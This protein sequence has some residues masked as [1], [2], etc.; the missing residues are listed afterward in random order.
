MRGLPLTPVDGFVLSRVDGKLTT[1]DLAA[2]TGLSEDQVSTS[3]DKLAELK[4]VA[5][6]PPDANP[7]PPVTP[8]PA[9]PAE[10]AP[11]P[12]PPLPP[13]APGPAAQFAVPED[14]PELQEVTD[15]ELDVRRRILG[16][17]SKLAELDHYELFNLERACD[18]KAVKRS[19]F[20][21]A[22]VFHPD[23]YFRKEIGSFKGMMEAIFGRATQAYEV[24]SDKT[25]RADYDAYLA[26]LDRTRGL[27]D[28][29]R[30]ALDDM[31]SAEAA[32]DSGRNS[33]PPVSS[34][35]H[36][37]VPTP[38]FGLTDTLRAAG[39]PSPA[40]IAAAQRALAARLMGGRAPR[41]PS[42]SQPPPVNQPKHDPG[43][44]LKRLHE[45]RVG[46][47][48]RAQLNKYLAMATEA[49]R[50]QDVIA[51]A[52]AYKVVLTV[53]GDDQ[54]IRAKAEK[55]IHEADIALADTYLR[56][57]QYEERSQSW[58]EAARSWGR[59]ASARPSDARAHDR[60]ANA[61]TRAEGDLHQAAEFAKKAI[62]M[63]GANAAFRVTLANVYVA[64]GLLK[65]ARRELEAALQLSPRDDT[66]LALLKR[67]PKA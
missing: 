48:R 9:A 41:Q 45:E 34:V 57:A 22:A 12:E 21:F 36:V 14:A 1:R 61:L 39:P 54:T 7:S 66:I 47:V 31:A 11:P 50:K 24:L 49:E 20:E 51:M 19:Y 18:K 38:A 17:F 16:L 59:V 6:G 30:S 27:D 33:A 53:A 52:H 23:K 58:A 55:A 29:L 32:A 63:D 60:A 13:P 65:N 3:L 28:M 2:S 42:A 67:V 4:V 64:A 15:L 56:Q 46:A 5:F 43:G 26:D 35:S 10:P 37:S 8:A 62:A 40:Q 44:A 25:A